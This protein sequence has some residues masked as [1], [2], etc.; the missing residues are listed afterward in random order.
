M[1]ANANEPIR[2]FI[3]TEPLGLSGEAGEQKIWE[4]VRKAFNDRECIGF[5][6]YP[7]FS[8]QSCY[9]ADILIAD[10]E[11]GLVIVEVKSIRLSDIE[12]IQGHRWQMKPG[13]Y[14][15]YISPFEQAKLQMSKLMGY[16]D[17]YPQ[18]REQIAQR[19]IVALPL[20]TKEEWENSGFS[21]QLNTPPVI[22]GNQLQG[23]SII[24]RIENKAI[25]WG[26]RSRLND[27]QWELLLKVI[28]GPVLPP[29]PPEHPNL[30]TPEAEAQIVERPSRRSVIEQV[31]QVVGQADIDQFHIGMEI[32]PG[33]QRIRGIAGSGK[34]ALLCQRAAHM[35]LKHPDWDIALVFFTRSLYTSITEL[36]DRWLRHFSDDKVKYS[37]KVQQKLRV[38]HAWGAKD[39]QGLY[40]RICQAHNV[41]RLTPT[42]IRYQQPNE[43]L[44]EACRLLLQSTSIQPMFD[45]ILID[46][47]QDLV[48]E[49]DLKFEDKQPFY[50]MAYQALR[51]VSPE[52]PHIRRLMWAYDEA[53]SLDSQKIPSAPELFGSDPDFQRLVTGFYAGGIKKSEI[54]HRCYRTPGP[55]LVA[56][57]AIGMGL[58]RTEGM[59][60]GITNRE[61]WEAVGYKVEGSFLSGRQVTLHRPPSN[62]PNPISQLWNGPTLDFKTYNNRNEE[63]AALAAN[64]KQN[65]KHDQLRPSREILV[66]V[67]GNHRESQMWE[68]RVAEYLKEQ[69]IDI[70]IPSAKSLNTLNPQWPNKK[71]NQFWHEG[72][73]TVSR[74]HRAKGNEAEMV[75]VVGFDNVAKDE[76]NI[77]LRN[78]VFVALTRAKAW[79]NLSGIGD[80]PMFDEMRK[81]IESGDTFTFTFQRPPKRSIE[82]IDA[83]VEE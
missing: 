39:Q 40:G 83:E 77:T 14:R 33:P 22:T 35:H 73:V 69:G 45:A 32:P 62:S 3:E 19:M 67:L 79:A 21:G 17:R 15:E 38:L 26:A 7:I 18:L 47:G 24:S 50:W 59:L 16:C 25:K 42:D 23:I 10:R 61:D 29:P 6:R 70:Y 20:I 51:P 54:M 43:A 55:I 58:L 64:I 60:S 44:A 76:G 66:I 71:P 37:L 8:G 2:R 75:Y 56:A 1:P 46:E 81:V 11:F 28:G 63:L 65:L 5:W 30:P 34:T 49:D 13:F 72:G 52:Q 12:S 53:Q 36:V 9:E 27:E 4:A 68:D 31:Q 48:I 82:E 57:H 80:Y 78:Q 41:Q 74:I